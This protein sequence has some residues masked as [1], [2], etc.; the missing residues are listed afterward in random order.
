MGFIRY[1]SLFISWLLLALCLVSPRCFCILPQMYDV[2]FSLGL[3]S[4][5]LVIAAYVYFHLFVSTL[6]RS[7]SAFVRH[8]SFCVHIQAYHSISERRV[9]G[10]LHSPNCGEPWRARQATRTSSDLI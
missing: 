9:V 8:Y 6:L 2:A 4:V 7:A 1:V 3:I 10:K 5:M